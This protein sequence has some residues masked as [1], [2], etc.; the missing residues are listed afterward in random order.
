MVG[1]VSEW[2]ADWAPKSLGCG[3]P[4]FGVGQNC[5]TGAENAPPGPGGTGAGTTALSRGFTGVYDVI[6]LRPLVARE[7]SLGFRAVR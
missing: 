1:N 2:V 6:G 4:L 3:A 5:F 7:Q